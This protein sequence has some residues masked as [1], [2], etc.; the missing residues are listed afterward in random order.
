MLPDQAEST[1]SSVTKMKLAVAGPLPLP[2]NWK[3]AGVVAVTPA[4][5]VE[6][7]PVQLPLCGGPPAPGTRG[8]VVALGVPSA[9]VPVL[10]TVYNVETPKSQIQKGLAVE[11]ALPHGLIRR[12]S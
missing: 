3:L 5:A 11:K 8:W 1:P 4:A 6:T 2:L 9:V 7:M 10:L 12:G